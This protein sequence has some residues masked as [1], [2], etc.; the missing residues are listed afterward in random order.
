[1]HLGYLGLAFIEGFALIIAPCILPILPIV[2]AAGVSGGKMRPYGII[3][4]FILSFCLFTLLSRQ[5]I[6][7]FHLSGDLIRQI[8]FYLLI[9]FGIVLMSNYLSNK[10]ASLTQGFAKVG[11]QLSDNNHRQ[12][13]W[14]GFLLGLPIGLIWTPC[15]GPIIAAIFVQIIRAKTSL[16]T[17]LTLLAFSIGVGVPML[18]ITLFGNRMIS[19]MSFFKKHSEL[20]RKLVGAII[21]V[22]VLITAQI[23]LF[24]KPAMAQTVNYSTLQ[25][26]LSQPYPAPE[27]T[28]IS[29]WINSTPL[30]IK[31][32]HGKVVLIDFWT[33][34][35]INCV[36]TLPYIISWDQKY[37]QQGLVIIGVH[38]PEFLF[39]QNLA[40]VQQAVTQ[41]KILYPVALDNNLDTWTNFNNQFWPAHYLIDKSGNVV[42]TH[43]GEG[44]YGIT[45]NN[46]RVLLGDTP[47]SNINE[48]AAFVS[49]QQTPET[50]LGYLRSERFASPT[51]LTG[52]YQ[53]P[54]HLD[55]HEWALSGDWHRGTEKITA[56]QAGAELEL[57]FYAKNVYLV[58]STESHKSIPVTVSLQGKS[59][60]IT[61][62]QDTLYQIANLAYPQEKIIKITAG[63]PGLSAYAFTFGN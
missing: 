61:V 40:N 2:L 47:L 41:D 21:I 15:A 20:I 8:S 44:D 29:A 53:Y 36:R 13:F 6:L 45:E 9:L 55:L 37:R 62:Q 19:Q 1:M 7:S 33:Y 28:G 42:Y 51:I 3:C 22:T 17:I 38:S 52:A 16:E 23:S 48:E 50:Y 18:L 24:I 56:E 49:D 39:E 60:V 43:F 63:A 30:T 32:L 12:G 59:T 10:F 46:I 54:D 58:M 5:L 14:G 4:G 57:H 26:A 27:I 11:N 31:Q 35:C 34:S 25:N